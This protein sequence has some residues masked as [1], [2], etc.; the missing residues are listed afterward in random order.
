MDIYNVFGLFGY[1][2][3]AA[4]MYHSD[5]RMTKKMIVAACC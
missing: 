5:D 2:I 1:A 3:I 4:G